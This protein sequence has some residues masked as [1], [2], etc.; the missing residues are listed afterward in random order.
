ML[1]RDL[2]EPTALFEKLNE[3]RQL[4]KRRDWLCGIPFDMHPA[5]ERVSYRWPFF[6]GR[7]LTRRVSRQG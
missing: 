6:Y 3:E 2:T 5:A 4:A 1:A 7:L